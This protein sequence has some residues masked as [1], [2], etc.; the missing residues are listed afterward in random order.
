MWF[1]YAGFCCTF[2]SAF[3]LFKQEHRSA[4][5]VGEMKEFVKHLPYIQAAKQ[6]LALRK[7]HHFFPPPAQ[8][9]WYFLIEI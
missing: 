5:T 1:L 9:L 7:Y 3:Y 2:I 4:K 6:S 8:F